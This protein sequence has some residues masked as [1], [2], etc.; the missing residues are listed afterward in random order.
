MHGRNEMRYTY[1]TDETALQRLRSVAEVFNPHSTNFILGLAIDSA[2]CAVDLGCGPG[3][4][5]RM[6]ARAGRA[7]RTCGI[8]NAGEFLRAAKDS[9]ISCDFIDHDVTELPFPVKADLMYSRF[10]LSH[11]ASPAALANRWLG[12]LA[13]GGLLLME[14]L[15]GIETDVE[16]FQRYLEINRGLVASQRARLYVGGELAGARYDYPVT[17][18]E[19][20]SLP[21][22]NARAA[23]MFY[24]NTINIWEEEDYVRRSLAAAERRE[25]SDVLRKLAG[26]NSDQSEIVWKMRRIA[27]LK[28][29]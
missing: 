8:D 2:Q 23:A 9:C 29:C 28:A 1:G 11:F 24:P 21:V 26:S 4:S 19:T 17:V 20:V 18:N 13:S 6:L 15:E 27:I 7:K 12:E 3:F 10:L 16:V 22:D 14:E 25:I 5:T